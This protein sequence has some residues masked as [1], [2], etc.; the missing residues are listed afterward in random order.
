MER[1]LNGNYT[2]MLRAVWNPA[3]QQLYDHLPPISKT[4]QTRRAR[5]AEHYWRSKGELISDVLLRIPLHGRAR[6]DRPLKL[7]Y[8]CYLPIQE[9]AWKTSLRRWALGK[10]GERGPRKSVP[11]ARDDDEDI[12]YIYNSNIYI[13]LYYFKKKQYSV[14]LG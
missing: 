2:R 6:V 1:K 13:Y 12:C 10:S 8:Y 11:A 14:T 7:I 3:K 4:F 9:V 5:H